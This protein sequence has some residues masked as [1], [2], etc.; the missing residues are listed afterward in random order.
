VLEFRDDIARRRP[1]EQPGVNE[2][3]ARLELELAH[4]RARCHACGQVYLPDHHLLL[5]PGCGST[6]GEVLGESALRIDSMDVEEDQGG[7]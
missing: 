4:V 3:G 5:C 7:P 2:D 1:L 6:E